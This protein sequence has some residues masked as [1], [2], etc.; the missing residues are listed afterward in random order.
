MQLND[1][2]FASLQLSNNTNT[3]KTEMDWIITNDLNA[4]DVF[5]RIIIIY[6]QNRQIK[7]DP[8]SWIRTYESVLWSG[9]K[10]VK[11]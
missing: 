11:L 8:Y 2:N 9:G 10:R 7:M 6:Q 3:I 5:K 4:V 1:L